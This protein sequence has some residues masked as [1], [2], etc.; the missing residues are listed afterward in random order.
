MSR[1]CMYI[2]GRDL[3][4][5]KFAFASNLETSIYINNRQGNLQ[6]F[7]GKES[8]ESVVIDVVNVVVIKDSEK[9]FFKSWFTIS[10]YVTQ[11][12]NAPYSI[13]NV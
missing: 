11:Q 13:S 5:L 2:Y 12:T 9:Y 1:V 3:R 10:L 4:S 7:E 6:N 8:D